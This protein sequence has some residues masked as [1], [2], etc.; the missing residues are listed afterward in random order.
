MNDAM[1][2]D[3][4]TCRGARALVILHERE[5]HR[6]VETWKAARARGVSVAGMRYASGT[7]LEDVLVHVPH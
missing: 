2:S 7:T 6:F 4:W 3:A 1:D 5:L